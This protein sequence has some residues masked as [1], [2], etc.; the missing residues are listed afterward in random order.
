M[1][2]LDCNYY[3]KEF[4]SIEELIDD[5]ITSGMDPNCEI[6]EDGEGIGE[7]AIDLICQ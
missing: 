1:F 7:Q 3:N 5:V 2:S 4:S 6:T